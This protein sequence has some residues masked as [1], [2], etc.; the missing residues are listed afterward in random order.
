[1]LIFLLFVTAVL[2]ETRESA[3]SLYK[4]ELHKQ[5]LAR[6]ALVEQSIE[7]EQQRLYDTCYEEIQ[8]FIREKKILGDGVTYL[9]IKSCFT[10]N[11][12]I[13]DDILVRLGKDGWKVDRKRIYVPYYRST[14][15]HGYYGFRCRTTYYSSSDSAKERYLTNDIVYEGKYS[16]TVGDHFYSLRSF[17]CNFPPPSPGSM[18]INKIGCPCNMWTVMFDT[19]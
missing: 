13:L 4:Q 9:W 12:T 3:A 6:A 17:I 5:E 15:Y 1:M 8:D 16:S 7:D 18:G 2:S 10:K 14:E 11:A 19:R